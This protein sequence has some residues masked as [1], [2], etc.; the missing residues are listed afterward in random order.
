MNEKQTNLPDTVTKI[1]ANGKDIYLVGTAHVSKQ[2]VDDV[3]TTVEAVKPDSICIELC[4]AR[5]IS[6][7]QKSAWKEM[8][9]FRVIKEKKTLFLLAQLLLASFYRKI[10]EQMGVQPG[11]EMLEGIKQAESTGAELVV[12]DRDVEI[13]LKRV[14]GHLGL[15][16]KMKLASHLMM[17][18]FFNEDIDDKL[19]E[20]MKEQD[21]LEQMME[22]FADEFPEI[23]KRLIDERDI[24][25]AQKIR[26]A[27]G[28]T[29]VAVVGAG[30]VPGMQKHMDED[31]DLAPLMELPPK[32]ILPTILKWAFPSLLIG[33]IVFAVF[34][35][36]KT[37]PSM[38]SIYIWFLV[39]GI[40]TALGAAL[41]LAH[42]LTIV[43]AF[44]AAPFTSLNPMIAAGW[45]TGLVQAGVRNPTVADLEDLPN[46]TAS[47]KG[48]W[49]NPA[50]RILLVV[51]M[52]NIGSSLGTF[53]AGSWIAMKV[54]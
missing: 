23:K 2:S 20:E 26:N 7:T 47:V 31:I 41:A 27:P 54:M 18:L 36:G 14:W 17:S 40:L 25:L 24:Y 3:K 49:T 32:S 53:I 12:A 42:P 8:N 21:Q 33:L 37:G 22:G 43:A 1:I 52:A 13:T 50:S 35:G 19:I 5:Y 39:N 15:W 6:M 16:N 38:E 9:L 10:G 29:I 46:A 51:V 30:H 45:V 4:E 11:A 28:T 44:L 48:F 34:Q